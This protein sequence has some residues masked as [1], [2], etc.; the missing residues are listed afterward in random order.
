LF[1]T[2]VDNLS[3]TLTELN[4]WRKFYHLDKKEQTGLFMVLQKKIIT[5]AIRRKNKVLRVF[6]GHFINWHRRC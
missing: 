5:A 2:I 6:A 1:S 4:L 3:P